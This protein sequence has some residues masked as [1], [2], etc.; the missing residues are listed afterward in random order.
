MKKGEHQKSEE[1]KARGFWLFFELL[2]LPPIFLTIAAVAFMIFG[3]SDGLWSG[4]FM[5]WCIFAYYTP[6][7]LGDILCRRFGKILGIIIALSPIWLPFALLLS[8]KLWMPI[9]GIH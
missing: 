3:G 1:Y 6:P 8:R 9:F 7:L 2:K 5:L 4:A